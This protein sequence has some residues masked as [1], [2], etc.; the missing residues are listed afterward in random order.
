[1]GRYRAVFSITRGASHFNPL[2]RVGRDD[3]L[4]VGYDE[5][6]L[7]QST[8]PRG[9]RLLVLILADIVRH[10]SIHAPAWG[11]TRRLR[12][13]FRQLEKFQSTRPRGARQ[14]LLEAMGIRST[15]SIH[16]PAWGATDG[17][18][19]VNDEHIISIHA[20]AWGATIGQEQDDDARKISIHAPAWGATEAQRRQNA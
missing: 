11:A 12:T 5:V 8:R 17:G 13:F 6:T 3:L 9:A 14:E 7:F 18:Q 4:H 2:A 10:I 15:I 20:P 16:A 19:P 1:M